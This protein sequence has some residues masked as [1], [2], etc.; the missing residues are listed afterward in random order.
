MTK[1]IADEITT[2]STSGSHHFSKTSIDELAD[3]GWIVTW[4]VDE[5]VTTGVRMQRYDASG[6][7]MGGE[8]NLGLLYSPAVTTLS[9]GG[10]LIAGWDWDATTNTSVETAWRFDASGHRVELND[11]MDGGSEFL[12][13]LPD[14]GWVG[15]DLQQ[16]GAQ[17]DLVQ[18]R[19]DANGQP[20]GSSVILSTLPYSGIYDSDVTV[21]EDGGWVATWNGLDTWYQQHFTSDGIAS[22][23]I[24]T[25]P[26]TYFY[27]PMITA[28]KD[29]G[30][31]TLYQQG[32]LRYTQRYDANGTKVGDGA[33]IGDVPDGGTPLTIAGLSNGGWA[34]AWSHLSDED[35]HY[36]DTVVQVYDAD[37]TSVGRPYVV[38]DLVG[39]D[40]RIEALD[41]GAFVVNWEWNDGQHTHV[42]QRIYR[43]TDSNDPPVAVDDVG[44]VAEG[45]QVQIDVLQ[46]DVVADWGDVLT[47]ESASVVQGEGSVTI[48]ESGQLLVTDAHDDLVKGQQAT[49]LIEYTM[50]DGFHT[51]T[52]ELVVTVNGVTRAGDVV[53]GTQGADSYRG[54]NGS[55]TYYGLGGNDNV[56]TKG[57]DDFLFGGD[58]DDKL[59]G[60]RGNDTLVGSKGDDVL[61]GG[62]GFNEFVIFRGDGR[63]R[64]QLGRDGYG[65]TLD[66]TDFNLRS[67]NQLYK[68]VKEKGNDLIIDLPGNGLLYIED[69]ANR[70][71]FADI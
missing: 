59:F 69:G 11:A 51:A 7:K 26:A 44:T 33:V 28:M 20:V 40:T 52:G 55:E 21:L 16:T 67:T 49:L 46:N 63:D 6:S 4:V 56:H 71:I 50:T 38:H 5:G 35:F 17:W 9:D 14:G 32:D 24:S 43:P 34:I 65:N 68:L 62:D 64:I 29:G 60:D 8:Q 12:A 70:A 23:A 13:G 18:Q 10:W 2:L 15:I 53:M 58:G 31:M 3:G 57:G 48:T 42:K 36:Y 54:I 25:Y 27:T 1:F 61:A 47:V 19:Y 30:W 37:G 22:G 45:E 39:V 66:L 41:G